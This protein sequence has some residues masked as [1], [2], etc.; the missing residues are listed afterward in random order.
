MAATSTN[1]SYRPIRV[2]L[3]VRIGEV[4]DIIQAAGVNSL[5]WGGRFN[6]LIP[7]SPS[8]TDRADRIAN[9]YNVDFLYPV[10]PTKDITDY[11]EKRPILNEGGF[12]YH[13]LLYS[14]Y[15][16]EKKRLGYLSVLEAIIHQW[17]NEFKDKADDYQS[18]WSLIKWEVGDPLSNLFAVTFGYYPRNLSLRDDYE[19]LFVSGLR[20]RID[21]V[22]TNETVSSTLA[23]RRTPL[24]LT[25]L[26]LVSKPTPSTT[27]ELGLYVGDPS[28]FRSLVNFWNLRAAG[29]RIQFLPKNSLDRYGDFLAAYLGLLDKLTSRN[30]KVTDRLNFYFQDEGVDYIRALADKFNTT[31]PITFVDLGALDN[32]ELVD[33]PSVFSFRHDRTL[34]VVDRN[35]IGY[36]VLVNLPEMKFLPGRD[37]EFPAPKLVATINSYSG[38]EYPNYT[39]RLPYIRSLNED[40]GRD[41]LSMSGY[42]DLRVEQDG[43]GV[44]VETS[45]RTLEMYP[46]SFYS[47]IQKVLNS[48]GIASS[49]SQAGLMT[50]RILEKIEGLFGASIFKVT[51]VRKL[52]RQTGVEKAITRGEATKQIF[53][54]GTIKR[55]KP[56]FSKSEAPDSGSIFNTLLTRDFF[57]AGLNLECKHCRLINWLP[58]KDI[59]DFW[60]CQYCGDRQLTSVQLNSRG[61]WHF[62][63]SGLFGKDNNQEGAIPVILTLSWLDKFGAFGEMIHCPA[64]NLSAP[65][66]KCEIDFC[67]LKF[68][69]TLDNVA[70]IVFG[71]CKDEGGLIND[72]DIAN[73]E[74]VWKKLK[75]KGIKSF[76]VFSKTASQFIDS[77]IELFRK[78]NSRD[79]PMILLTTR[80]L[81]NLN[82]RLSLGE[83]GAPHKHPM[84]LEELAENCAF[85]YLCIK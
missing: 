73:L 39:L 52:I 78:L 44:I 21:N 48:A 28:D 17:S 41:V 20:P 55:F 23:D 22:T 32:F 84:T 27:R 58:L 14:D 51:G 18:N 77:E 35:P 80:E 26:M 7:F 25:S 81:E 36:K 45:D 9:S 19:S 62:R 83:D 13:N 69:R 37:F 46:I 2:G 64:L 68:N 4:E 53:D 43:V 67:G 15:P 82:P 76:I 38:H 6:P 29:N 8:D 71:E 66:L 59:D 56:P 5:L 50:Q 33:K 74:D 42:E 57:R 79:V 49:L 10:V 1:I 30:A 12:H 65:D 47:V 72:E 31:K 63:R 34:S 70:Q 3:L 16:S 11:L 24:A 61:E 85:R 75:V 40:F 54:D 60:T